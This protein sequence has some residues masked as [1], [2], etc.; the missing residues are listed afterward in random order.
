MQRWNGDID[1]LDILQEFD[2]EGSTM[3]R[4]AAIMNGR[5][6]YVSDLD[7]MSPA[8]KEFSPFPGSYTVQVQQHGKRKTVQVMTLAR[9]SVL[10]RDPL[11]MSLLQPRLLSQSKTVVMLKSGGVYH[12]C[13]QQQGRH[14]EATVPGLLPTDQNAIGVTF[15]Q[16]QSQQRDASQKQ[17]DNKRGRSPKSMS[18][19]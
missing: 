12:Y 1:S 8:C 11:P 17:T 10:G 5:W 15:A 14:A 7:A 19:D 6:V 9:S 16:A 2:D 4:R 18:G 3:L 13:F